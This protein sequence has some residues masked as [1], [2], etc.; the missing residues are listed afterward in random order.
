MAAMTSVANDLYLIELDI[1]KFQ[2]KLF[3]C[4]DIKNNKCTETG[5]LMAYQKNLQNEQRRDLIVCD[6]MTS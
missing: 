2:Y 4:Y 6:I 1:D 3:S 5:Y